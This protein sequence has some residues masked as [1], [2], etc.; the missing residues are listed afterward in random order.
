MPRSTGLPCNASVTRPGM[1]PTNLGTLNVL[2]STEAP[3]WCTK[4]SLLLLI[5]DAPLRFDPVALTLAALTLILPLPTV[6]FNVSALTL[7]WW[8]I[9]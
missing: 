5:T 3:T 6:V 7:A 9:F 2:P 8:V 1:V 4:S